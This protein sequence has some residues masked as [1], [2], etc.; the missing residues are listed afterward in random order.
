MN[1]RSSTT[2]PMGW[3]LIARLNFSQTQLTLLDQAYTSLQESVY[4]S[5]VM[6]TRLRPYLDQIEL[7]IDDAGIRLDARALNTMLANKL[8]S[9]PE[10]MLGDLLDLDRYAD[11]DKFFYQFGNEEKTRRA[12]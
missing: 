2:R 12:A 8:T 6:Q 7:V 5:L 9:D 4:A 1:S 11:N 3:S 10:T